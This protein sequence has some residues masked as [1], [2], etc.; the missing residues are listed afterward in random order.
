MLNTGDYN[1]V[2]HSLIAYKDG[3][4]DVLIA[5]KPLKKRRDR[6]HVYLL[7]V[8]PRGYLMNA[9]SYVDGQGA[10]A[11]RLIL[12]PNQNRFFVGTSQTTVPDNVEDP[13]AIPFTFDAWLVGVP[14][15]DPYSDPCMVNP[16]D[17]IQ[18]PPND[19]FQ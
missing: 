8:S 18:P 16:L 6:P 9:K 2:G 14:S 7:T 17:N 19:P 5:G 12:G 10:I 13:S 15:L 3:R 1:Y 11:K 4:T